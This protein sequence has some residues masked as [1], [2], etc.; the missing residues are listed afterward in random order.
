MGP[1]IHMLGFFAQQYIKHTSEFSQIVLPTYSHL[2]LSEILGKKAPTVYD[3][4]IFPI[5]T[6]YVPCSDTPNYHNFGEN[7]IYHKIYHQCPHETVDVLPQRSLWLVAKSPIFIPRA[8][9]ARCC[10]STGEG[11]AKMDGF[12]W[13][14]SSTPWKWPRHPKNSQ[15]I[16]SSKGKSPSRAD[17]LDSMILC[18]TQDDFYVGAVQPKIFELRYPRMLTS[19]Q[20]CTTQ[21]RIPKPFK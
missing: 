16:L 1:V 9:C 3:F 8:R 18:S 4:S 6:G 13:S 7:Y 21:L 10:R 5:T 19:K 15:L 20:G 14:V 17:F 11:L 2:G 12:W